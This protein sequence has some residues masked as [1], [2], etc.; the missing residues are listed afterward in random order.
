MRNTFRSRIGIADSGESGGFADTF[1]VKKHKVGI[2]ADFET[3]FLR[4]IED[5]RRDKGCAAHGLNEGQI[6][7]FSNHDPEKTGEM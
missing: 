7:P 3:A 1:G 2:E 5:G 4:E 6:P